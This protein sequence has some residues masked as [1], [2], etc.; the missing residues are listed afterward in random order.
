[1]NQ[2][3][4]PPSPISEASS[5]ENDRTIYLIDGTAYIYRAYH[6]IR[7][8]SNSKGLPTNA[9]FGFARMLIKFMTERSPRYAVM[10]F[11]A[12]GPTF[13]HQIYDAYKANRPPMPEDMAVQIPYIKRVAAGFNLPILE[14][15]GFEADDLIGT[16]ARR[17]EAN[18]FAV[19][20]VSGDKDFM[21][22]VTEK[23]VL[24]DP[25][26]EKTVDIDTIRADYGVE[27]AQI[28]DMMGLS[29]DTADNIPGVPGIGPKTA[30]TLIQAHVSMEQLYEEIDD[31]KS[32]KKLYEKLLEFKDQAFLSKKLVTIDTDVTVSFQ[33]EAYRIPSPDRN[34]LGDLFQE[35]EF[36][37][38]QQQF[39]ELKPP[40]KKDYTAIFDQAALDHL[41]DQI[42]KASVFA[43][44]T[45]TTSKNP[46]KA[47]LVGVSVALKPHE[48]FYIP[49]G[50]DYPNVP[51]QLPRSL[52]I[53][54]LKPILEDPGT[55]KIGQNI[56]YDWTVLRRLGIRLKGVVFDTMIASYLINPSKRAHNLD[57]IALD[58]LNHKTT[59]Y[60]EVVGKNKTGA[61]F[62]AVEIGKATPYACEDADIT[63][64]ARDA[65]QPRLEKL[66]LP[67]L[68]ETVE[69]PLIDVLRRMEMRGVCVDRQRLRE[70]S[71]TFHRELESLE[72]KIYDLVGESFNIKS[73]QQLGQVL[74]EKLNL[75]VQKKTRKKTGYSTDVEVLT[76]LSEYHPVPGLVLRHRTL[77]KLKS[78][79]A[80]A[81]LDL[82]H[83]ETNRIH[84]SY[85]Q[86]VTA[87]GRLS[88]SDPNLQNIP[89]RTEEGRKIRSAFVPEKGWTLLSADYSQIELRLLAH[90]SKD[91]ILIK[92]FEDDE[93]IHRRTAAE[94]FQV[95]P[96]DISVELRRQAKVI[97]FGIIYGM[98]AF[99]LAKE[100][101][102]THK[103]AATYID[104]Y[105]ARYRGVKQFI[106]ETIATVRSTCQTQTLLGRIR[107]LPEINS[108][109]R[110]VRSF[111]E[112]TA[113]NTPIQGSAADLIKLAM[114]QTENELRRQELN[115]A[116]LLSVHDEIVFEV[117][118][119]ELEQTEKLVTLV[120]EGVWDLK[121]PLKV[122]LAAG[123]NWAE[124]H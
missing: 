111:A 16:V 47:E 29:G 119:G 41:I 92:A 65:L 69:M 77:S 123:K 87:T 89:I 73:S 96:E 52:L 26:K 13:R 100:L 116:M 82:I 2:E 40:V 74:F 53:E 12:K 79:Y 43:L 15:S 109:N 38:L 72:M 88:S 1:M 57:Q 94:V 91:E 37:Q 104:N 28:I 80:D 6:A 84:T 90:C 23:V 36:R 24:W 122:N 3:T 42:K 14:M 44:D 86:T 101:G 102:I 78:T 124:A 70:L 66:G 49:C 113:V 50:H 107:L 32:K 114:I 5:G 46:M 30:K 75:P 56:K 58:F 10:F 22:L 27:P 55:G 98:G 34:V 19:V 67:E 93:D 110:N 118:P 115:T 54:R 45:E 18:G 117:P 21:Q 39:T 105:F 103:M 99:S 8:L 33:A 85:N 20:M 62:E 106:D 83:P 64:M 11:D 81:L 35:L 61:G 71:D 31:L 112:R 4:T 25:M 97:N 76:T 59:T 108:R 95:A 63:L 7:N 68:F 51:A 121:V 48:A 60:K 17:A 120:M 9:V